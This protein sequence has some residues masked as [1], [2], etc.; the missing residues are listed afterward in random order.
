MPGAMAPLSHK[1]WIDAIGV[2]LSTNQSKVYLKPD[3]RFSTY[4]GI[5]V[6]YQ[7]LFLNW[8]MMAG[9]STTE[10]M[11]RVGDMAVFGKI[12]PELKVEDYIEQNDSG[13]KLFHYYLQMHSWTRMLR[14][15]KMGDYIDEIESFKVPSTTDPKALFDQIRNDFMPVLTKVWGAHLRITMSAS[16]LPVIV[17]NILDPTLNWGPDIYEDMAKLLSNCGEDIYSADVPTMMQEVA[18]SIKSDQEAVEKFNSMDRKDAAQ[19]LLSTESG[20]HGELFRKFLAKHGH[21]CVRDSDIRETTWN[22]EPE[23]VVDALKAMML[24]TDLHQSANEKKNMMSVEEAMESLK[25]PLKWSQRFFLKMLLPKARASVG[26]REW[27]K[28]YG[29][30]YTDNVRRCY[31]RLSTLLTERNFLPD[32]DLIFF[33]MPDEIETLIKRRSPQLISRALR[34]RKNFANFKGLNFKE[35][36]EG[37]PQPIQID[38]QQSGS[39]G[40]VS[41]NGMAVGQGSVTGTARVVT[42][43]AEANSIEEGEIL[44]VPYTDVGWTPYFP[45]IAGLVTELGGLISHGAVVAREYGLP[46]LVNCK[47]AT[48]IIKT[49]DKVRIDGPTSRILVLEREQDN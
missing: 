41:I 10:S 21:R 36:S 29:I 22:H 14:R 6:G 42:S 31:Q 48:Q 49:G 38:T 15:E 33:L 32:E 37:H 39:G 24:T 47:A 4:R 1:V 46:C 23:K 3:T 17:M 19:W 30:K 5:T 11:K 25:T 28:S 9:G 40:S 34:R 20:K 45:L 18:K 16:I 8:T 27:A 26:K 13:G 2:P 43:L 35:L 7:H 12:V 44:I